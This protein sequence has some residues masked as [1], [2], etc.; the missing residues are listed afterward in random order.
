MLDWEVADGAS[1]FRVAWSLSTQKL[2]QPVMVTAIMTT[3]GAEADVK[4]FTF[5]YRWLTHMML[6]LYYVVTGGK[7]LCLCFP[8]MQ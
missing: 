8:T 3:A 7:A 2:R 1:H 5:L 4:D 6:L